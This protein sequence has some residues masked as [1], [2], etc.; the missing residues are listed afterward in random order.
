MALTKE[1]KLKA[2]KKRHPLDGERCTCGNV[3][4]WTRRFGYRCMCANTKPF[5]PK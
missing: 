2:Y 4:Y 5:N 1:Q 3:I